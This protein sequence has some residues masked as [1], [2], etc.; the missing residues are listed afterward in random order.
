MFGHSLTST[1]ANAFVSRSKSFGIW[2]LMESLVAGGIFTMY[3]R[4]ALQGG[5][6][7]AAQRVA[8]STN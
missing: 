4:T 1:W 6:A 7:R 3:G 5:R 8:N 2:V